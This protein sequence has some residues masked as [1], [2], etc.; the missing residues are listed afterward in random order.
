MYKTVTYKDYSK[1]S[2]N[3]DIKVI[4]HGNLVSSILR[5]DKKVSE[6][7]S[8]NNEYSNSSWSITKLEIDNFLSYGSGNI[9]D[10]TKLGGLTLVP[11]N[12]RIG[13]TSFCVDAILFLLFN[14]TTR[15]SKSEEIFNIYSKNDIVKVKGWL[16]INNQ[17]YIIERIIT[18]K[19]KKDGSP[20]CSTK[21]NFY[22]ELD[23][24]EI[25]N[26]EGEQRQETDKIIKDI[27][28]NEDDFLMSVLITGDSLMD[29][30]DLKATAR[31]QLLSRYLGLNIF[32]EKE[33]ICKEIYSDWKK[34]LK[35]NLYDISQV[36]QEIEELKE[37]NIEYDKQYKE[38]DQKLDIIKDKVKNIKEIKDSLLLKLFKIDDNLTK[39]NPSL[40][41]KK[42]KDLD[43]GIKDKKI[44]LKDFKSQISK[45]KGFYDKEEHEKVR[46]ENGVMLGDIQITNNTIR[47]IKEDIKNFEDG[48]ICT[49]CNRPFDKVDHSK[50]IKELEKQLM[51]NETLLKKQDLKSGKLIKELEQ[52]EIKREQSEQKDTSTLKRDKTEIEIETLDL[53]LQKEKD[54]LESYHKNI[55]KIK[56]N[57]IVNKDIKEVEFKLYQE[58]EDEKELSSKLRDVDYNIK[59]NEKQIEENELIVKDINKE[60]EIRRVFISYLSLVGKNGVSKSILQDLIP[61]INLE[62]S[63]LLSDTV[64]FVPMIEMN[65]NNMELQLLLKDKD[66]N[67]RQLKTG[68][69]F[70]R[71]ICALSI[72]VIL[73]KV[74]SLSKPDIIILDEVLGKVSEENLTL[75]EGFFQ[76][77][78]TEF[79]N[80]LLITHN[81]KIKDIGDSIL[82]IEKHNNISKII[83]N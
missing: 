81:E 82:T 68:S 15:T 29:V 13:K 24:G 64:D 77:L 40:F 70:E 56:Q 54:N 7:L 65:L 66:G 12:N 80:I 3:N 71:T 17:N 76:K 10:F 50:E 19:W 6:Q 5:L 4:K 55:D 39:S 22:K 32:E 74:N 45:V 83:Q 43:K 30:I 33:T 75:M 57:E 42:I 51:V 41:E 31:G 21:L 72:R 53:K 67:T 27:I 61:K 78:R 23:N 25:E 36:K 1:L 14:K 73:S 18:R 44:E 58:E 20:N 28:G 11:G 16:S 47:K 35:S 37:D 79:S 60:E 34:T 48:K 26:L 63:K 62:L 2:E 49:L 69:G 52:Y 9:I 38:L 8:N 59:N 46:I